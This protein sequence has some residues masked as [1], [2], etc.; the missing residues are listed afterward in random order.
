MIITLPDKTNYVGTDAHIGPIAECNGAITVEHRSVA[1][2]SLNQFVQFGEI[3]DF[4][5]V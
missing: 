3:K 2:N 4:P 1:T 5:F